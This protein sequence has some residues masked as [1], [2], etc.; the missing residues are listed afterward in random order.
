MSSEAI[1][2]DYDPETPIQFA[3]VPE[4]ISELLARPSFI[5][6]VVFT[7]DQRPRDGLFHFRVASTIEDDDA[8]MVLKSVIEELSV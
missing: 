8:V 5:G 3:T 6:T 2:A 1:D 4:L 7:P